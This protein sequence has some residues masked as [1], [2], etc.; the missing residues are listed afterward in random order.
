VRVVKGFYQVFSGLK[1]ENVGNYSL[2]IQNDVVICVVQ[3]IKYKELDAY[4]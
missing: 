3:R 2:N 1:K 4:I